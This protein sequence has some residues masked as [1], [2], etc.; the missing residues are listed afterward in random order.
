M[1]AKKVSIKVDGVDDLQRKIDEIKES[2]DNVVRTVKAL[3]DAE[4]T[5]NLVE[6]E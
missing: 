6:S 1:K 2:L 5:I 3:Q 4:V